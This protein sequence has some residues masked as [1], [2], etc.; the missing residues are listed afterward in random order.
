MFSEVIGLCISAIFQS[1]LG[2][3][4][5]P[6][7]DLIN[8]DRPG[9]ADGS[10]VIGF[11]RYQIE[12]GGQWERHD[13]A[14]TT[15]R[16]F[17]VPA[18]MR[19]GLSDRWELRL[20]TSAAY[21][22]ATVN[23]QRTVGGAPTSIGAKFHFQDGDGPRHPSYGAIVRISP[24]SGSGIF[25]ANRT[26]VD[27]RFAADWD[28]V[29]GGLWSLNPNIG[30]AS[31]DGGDGTSF[32]AGLY[33]L[34]VNYNPSSHLNFFIDAGMQTPEQKNGLTGLTIDA[35]VALIIGENLQLDL[36]AGQGVKGQTTPRPFIGFGI[37]RRF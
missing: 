19:Y 3:T 15:D 16:R 8:A 32:L 37:S 12:F 14:G 17:F 31:Y 23:G 26:Q 1:G 35:G 22:V 33:A 30:I 20:E 29:K 34:T 21:A 28:L 7:V 9:L 10:N 4:P 24:A 13:S 11:K 27:L 36:S 5:A 25:G 2:Q 6:A 18:L